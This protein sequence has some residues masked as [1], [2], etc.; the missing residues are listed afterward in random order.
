MRRLFLLFLTLVCTLQVVAQSEVTWQDF[1]DEVS[2]D[3]LVE[4][5]GWM[6]R[7]EELEQLTTHKI[8]LNTASREDLLQLPW[9]G[10]QQVDEI[11]MYI[12]HHRGMRDLAE[13]MAIR[14]LDYRV[15]RFLPL[16]VYV[17]KLESQ[18]TD[19]KPY[20]PVKQELSTLINI[21]LYYRAGYD[22]PVKDGGYA[23]NPLYHRLTYLLHAGKRLQAGVSMEKDAGEPFRNNKGWD[24]YGFHAML[25]DVGCIS[26][27]VVGDYRLGFGEGLVMNTAFGMGKST[28]L[29]Q[30]TKGIRAKIGSDEVNYLRGTAVAMKWND[31]TLTAWTSHRRLDATLNED[32]TVKTIV[33]SGLHRT[34]TELDKKGNLGSTLA[35]ADISWQHHGLQ[36]GI[37]G[38]YE[39]MH[40]SLEPGNQPYRQIMPQGT[41]FGVM[42]VH[43]GYFQHRF[44]LSGETAYSTQQ[45]GI[46]TLHRL[47]FRFNRQYRLG[48]IQRYYNPH[49]YSFHS[50]AISES[51][52]VQNENGVMLRLEAQPLTRWTLSGYVDLFYH[53]WARYGINHSSQGQDVMMES[54]HKIN[55]RN[56]WTIRY[57][58][59]HKETS[60]A[61][62]SH[63]RVRVQWNHNTLRHWD[64]QS[65]LFL[66]AVSKTG[67]AVAQ[68]VRYTS[69][70]EMWRMALLGT[71][72]H[73]PD[74]DTRIYVYEPML[75]RT[76]TFPMLSGHGVHLAGTLRWKSRDD[77]WT[78]ECKYGVTRF[79]DRETQGSGLQEIFSPWKNDI[80]LQMSV[81]I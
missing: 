45:G 69:K 77:R 40:R 80:S 52:G 66:H 9:L 11:Q 43:Y 54:Q 51:G 6:D 55:K 68:R 78:A 56:Q 10:E 13:L 74:Y 36:A 24:A 18:S 28:L 7:L 70:N 19:N 65:S 48:L 81:K 60:S 39:H 4:D 46:A 67:V 29:N 38:Y 26:K 72:F 34:A 53:P 33:E 15:R 8:N 31:V 3:E 21:P 57:Q 16:F 14:S 37:T 30:P 2:E 71:W 12:F 1:I 59:K 23:G 61:F 42:G 63:H 50:S 25:Q 49:Y 62:A 73:T 20:T 64:Y 17:D 58:W 32:S 76:M 47:I 27:L 22:K 41:D 35:G 75:Y 79:L 5:D 44:S